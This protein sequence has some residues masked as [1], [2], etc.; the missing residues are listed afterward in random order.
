MNHAFVCLTLLFST[1]GLENAPTKNPTAIVS[2]DQGKI[3][4]LVESGVEV[5][6]GI[7]YAAPPVGDLRWK[8]PAPP[9][10]WQNIRDCFEFG[11]A[12]PQNNNPLQHMLPLGA[13]KSFSEDCLSL[14]V[15]RPATSTSEKLPVMFWIHGGGFGEGSSG[16]GIYDGSSLARKGAV[17]VTINYRLGPYGFLAHPLLTAESGS[18]GNYGILDQIA[19]LQWVKKNIGHFG[20]D[21]DCVTIFGES[22]GGA[23]VVTL[24]VSPLSKGLF[25]RAIIQSTP[26][27]SVRHLKKEAFGKQSAEAQGLETIAKCGLSESA[28]LNEMRKIPSATLLQ[29]FPALQLTGHSVSLTSLKLPVEPCVDG[30][31]LM[32]DPNK[33]MAEGR[34]H[35]V[36]VIVGCTREEAALFLL[37]ATLPTKKTDAENIVRKEFGELGER[38]LAHYPLVNE[39]YG[40]RQQ[41]GHLLTD[42]VFGAESRYIARNISKREPN[43][44]R[45]LFSRGSRI[46]FLTPMGAHHGA[47]VP[48]VLQTNDPVWRWKDWDRELSNKIQQYWVN[49]AKTGD[50]NGDDLPAWP[51]YDTTTEQTLELGDTITVIKQYR[52]EQHNVVDEH[53][54]WR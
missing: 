12:C 37:L 33:S 14:N 54:N 50:P 1:A 52:H 49:F 35:Q 15:Y 19:A 18:S 30:V 42:L 5:F 31:V 24:L 27:M 38:I 7:P 16:M 20:G 44:Y 10:H 4:G 28:D 26:D 47:D 43:T 23:S 48:Y 25:H 39:A 13:I 11:P 6:R 40:I 32:E 3:R 45:F 36:P 46:P 41:I 2:I 34:F 8:P 9:A 29:K 22:A 53:K 21:P 17:V 51:K